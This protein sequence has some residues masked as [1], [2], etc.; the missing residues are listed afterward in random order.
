MTPTKYI[1]GKRNRR[2]D[3]VTYLISFCKCLVKDK[4]YQELQRIGTCGKLWSRTSWT[5]TVYRRRQRSSLSHLVIKYFS[6]LIFHFC[7]FF[8]LRISDICTFL[9]S[10]HYSD[11]LVENP[12]RRQFSVLLLKKKKLNN[13]ITKILLLLKKCINFSHVFLF[14]NFLIFY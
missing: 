3:P 4:I 9:G 7:S 5:D 6:A 1:Y 10:E 2:K 13:P 12:Y 11:T 14:N 8:P